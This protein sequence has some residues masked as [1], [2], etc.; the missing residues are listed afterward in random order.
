LRGKVAR[1]GAA[2]VATSTAAIRAL[3]P[4]LRMAG[5]HAASLIGRRTGFGP[6]R[7]GGLVLLAA[8]VFGAGGVFG[9]SVAWL[10]DTG[11]HQEERSGPPILAGEDLTA[12]VVAP[13]FASEEGEAEAMPPA[14]H[15]PPPLPRW[16][17]HAV[18]APEPDGRPMIAVIIDDIGVNRR[19]SRRAI[20]LP[21]PLTLAFLSYADRLDELVATARAAGHELL[22]HIPM[23]PDSTDVDPGANVL[24]LDLPPS[25]LLQRLSWA[26]DRFDGYV[27]INNHMGSKF[28]ASPVAM[29]HV[30]LALKARGLL[31][32]DSMTAP[33]SVGGRMARHVGVPYAE[34]DVFLDNETDPGSIRRQLAKLEALARKRGYAVAIGHPYDS[35]LEVLGEWLGQV[36]ARGFALVPVSAVVRHR[37]EIAASQ[38]AAG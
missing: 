30:M 27:G 5:R 21:K 3:E 34:R 37:R 33:G 8:A 32:V 36:E 20:A 1:E 12:F 13:D 2:I 23:E 29:A 17:R 38:E 15:T 35:T 19:N 22:V 26:L 16:Q 14:A 9:A 7:A 18:A 25:E 6:G 4:N 11:T 10:V 31:F 24:R 28:T